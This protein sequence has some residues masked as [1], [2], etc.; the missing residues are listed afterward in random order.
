MNKGHM[1]APMEVV[2]DIE[3]KVIDLEN[4]L[5]DVTIPLL[6]NEWVADGDTYTYTVEVEGVTSEYVPLVI[7]SSVDEI[8]TTEELRA[9]H[10]ITDVYATDGIIKFIASS[11]PDMSFTVIA[12]NATIAE[13]TVVDVTGL[14][15]KINELET[16]INNISNGLL[17]ESLDITSDV[18]YTSVCKCGNIVTISLG[19]NK[20]DLVN[21]TEYKVCDLPENMIPV[22]A[23]SQMVTLSKDGKCGYL[24]VNTKGEVFIKPY[25]NIANGSYTYNTITFGTAI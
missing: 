10:C 14:V 18:F 19:R 13:S 8:A 3:D 21:D 20:I 2:Q 1:M 15:G 23:V 25:A 5:R 4:K 12:K 9:Y 7:L 22:H 24:S 16:E 6:M 11:K 17:T